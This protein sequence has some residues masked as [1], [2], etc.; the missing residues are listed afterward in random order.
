MT[1]KDIVGNIVSLMSNTWGDYTC[2]R[3]ILQNGDYWKY[4]F[5]IFDAQFGYPIFEDIFT[6]KT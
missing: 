1:K 5:W 2:P 4:C 6:L 3:Q